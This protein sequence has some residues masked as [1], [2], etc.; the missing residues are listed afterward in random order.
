MFLLGKINVLAVW[1]YW[2][3]IAVRHRWASRNLLIL[4]YVELITYWT[5]YHELAL[6]FVSCS[7][8]ISIVLS[9]L[10][11]RKIGYVYSFS[12][13]A[14][15]GIRHFLINARPLIITQGENLDITYVFINFRCEPCLCPLFIFIMK[16]RYP[17]S[18]PFFN[19]KRPR[20]N[21]SYHSIKW[22]CSWNFVALR[23]VNFSGS[24]LITKIAP[25]NGFDNI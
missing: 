24:K 21:F 16:R 23:D 12:W 7:S 18:W 17:F 8:R 3:R 2:N 1:R 6:K 19:L 11:L 14:R 25:H 22:C 10:G 15:A 5:I 4:L 13:P 9:Q 20:Y